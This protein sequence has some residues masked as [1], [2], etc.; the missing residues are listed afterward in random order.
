MLF[1]DDRCLATSH[2][3]RLQ[4]FHSFSDFNDIAM[5]IKV[6]NRHFV[7]ENHD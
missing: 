3:I 1:F 7:K 2:D 5:C 4:M 6:A